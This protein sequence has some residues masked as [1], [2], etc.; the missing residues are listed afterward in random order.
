MSFTA[1]AVRD[2]MRGHVSRIVSLAPE[3]RR[4]TAL[5]FAAKILRLPV[6][7]VRSLYYG[8]ARRIIRLWLASLRGRY[9]ERRP[10][11]RPNKR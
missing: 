1:E 10:L 11:K 8:E 2:E 9:R 6:C 5:A 7:R 4:K 3:D